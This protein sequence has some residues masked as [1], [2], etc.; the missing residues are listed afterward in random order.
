MVTYS[1]DLNPDQIQEIYKQQ[2]K[3]AN[4]IYYRAELA[5]KLDHLA[6]VIDVRLCEKWIEEGMKFCEENDCKW[7]LKTERTKTGTIKINEAAEYWKDRQTSN[8]YSNFITEEQAAAAMEFAKKN[9]A[10]QDAFEA[11]ISGKVNMDFVED[12]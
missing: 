4:D 10:K 2:G 6:R 1:K 5:E 8:H 11:S 3:A 7:M 9:K 12:D